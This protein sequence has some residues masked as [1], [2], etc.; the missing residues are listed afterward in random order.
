VFGAAAVASHAVPTKARF[1]RPKPPGRK[2]II[3]RKKD[4]N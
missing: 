4:L 1:S 3:S 2:W